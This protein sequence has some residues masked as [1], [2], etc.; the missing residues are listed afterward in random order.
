MQLETF[1]GQD[2]PSVIRHVRRTLGESAM[3]VRT[4]VAKRESG[5][6]VEVVAAHPDALAAFERRLDG[7][8]AAARRAKGRQRIGPY[9]IALVGPAGAG[10]TTAAMKLALHPKGLGD[11]TVGL[12]TLD[13]YRA[14]AV[15]ELQT[16]AEIARLP[17]EVVYHAREI[18]TALERLREC[19]VVV[20][21]TPGRWDERAEWLSALE[22]VDADEI[23]LVLPA[24]LRHEVALRWC[25]QVR[26]AQVTHVLLS[27]LDELPADHGLAELAEALDLPARWI[28]GGHEI[29]GALAPAMPRIL[30][31]L[32]LHGGDYTP[33]RQAG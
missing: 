32:G 25:E 24:G 17:L 10:K 31:S 18:P 23:H 7:G 28:S 3:I 12:I 9:T 22:A 21:D 19:D 33:R 2:L 14:G 16:Y 30:G 5:D 1:R 20:V 26:S 4:Q 6:V 27:R 8:R 11:R 15:D 13:T 29:P